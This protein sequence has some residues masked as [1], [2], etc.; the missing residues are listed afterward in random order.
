MKKM[1]INLLKKIKSLFRKKS[2]DELYKEQNKK[3]DPFIY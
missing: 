3:D 2:I 1:L